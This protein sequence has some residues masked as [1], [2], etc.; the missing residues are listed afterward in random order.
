MTM[1]VMMR[2]MVIVASMFLSVLTFFR[3]RPTVSRRVPLRLITLNL[4]MLFRGPGCVPVLAPLVIVMIIGVIVGV[5]VVA[6]IH[7]S[8]SPAR[9]PNVHFMTVPGKM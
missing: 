3:S 7:P 8:P 4:P 9:I 6:P 5:C 1:I 2:R